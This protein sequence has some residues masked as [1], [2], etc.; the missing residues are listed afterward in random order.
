M[1]SCNVDN[2]GNITSVLIITS[3]LTVV[4][5]TSCKSYEF[6]QIYDQR[7]K[8]RINTWSKINKQISIM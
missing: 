2:C 8:K 7:G 6:G 5:H 4:N 1:F 3:N